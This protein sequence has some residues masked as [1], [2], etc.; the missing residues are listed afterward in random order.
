MKVNDKMYDNFLKMLIR[1]RILIISDTQDPSYCANVTNYFSASY[2][3]HDWQGVEL[4][5]VFIDREKFYNV[6]HNGSQNYEG[7]EVTDTDIFI[8]VH[9]DSSFEVYH[10]E[11][12]KNKIRKD[13]KVLTEFKSF[14]AFLEAITWKEVDTN[15]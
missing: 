12:Q 11:L 9:N 13:Y 4:E 8:R 2:K 14:D 3:D 10:T 15:A 5:G 6:W 1:K 7:R